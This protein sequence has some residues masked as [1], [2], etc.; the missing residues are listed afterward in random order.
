[1]AVKLSDFGATV[2][3]GKGRAK[4]VILEVDFT[5]LRAWAKRMKVKEAAIWRKAYKGAIRVLKSKFQKVI[6]NFSK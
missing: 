5:E 4:T 2:T 3:A 1:M 6:S